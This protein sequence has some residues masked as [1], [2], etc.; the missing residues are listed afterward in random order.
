D[1]Q[2]RF[3]EWLS[4]P[5]PTT[6]HLKACSVR[7]DGSARWFF[8]GSKFKEWTTN[9]N[10]FWIHGKVGSGKTVLCSAIVDQLRR[11]NATRSA[12]VVYFYC[13][14]QDTAKQDVRGLLCSFL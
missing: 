1:L 14:F 2:R 9:G 3:R 10:L 8:N 5:D 12:A 4:P 6:N 7:R 11:H 13:D